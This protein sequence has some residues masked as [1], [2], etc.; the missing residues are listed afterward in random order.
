M[1]LTSSFT[2]NCAFASTGRPSRVLHLLLGHN[3]RFPE[4][5]FWLVV[6]QI[7]SG[8]VAS[9][10]DVLANSA[11]ALSQDWVTGRESEAGIMRSLETFEEEYKAIESGFKGVHAPRNRKLKASP[12]AQ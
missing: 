11:K 12:T 7:L 9:L 5:D 8:R 1:T 2:V 4:D 10:A 6:A 3:L